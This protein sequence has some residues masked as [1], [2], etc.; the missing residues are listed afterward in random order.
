MKYLSVLLAV[1]CLLTAVHAQWLE[2]TI[3]LDSG[4]SPSALCYNPQNNKV[5]CAN[6]G[7]GTVSVI[8]GATN[9]IAATIAIGEEA[10]DLSCNPL[11]NKVYCAYGRD[12]GRLAVIDGATDSVI[13]TIAVG[14]YPGPLCLGLQDNKVY[15][16]GGEANQ[17]TV[18]D[19]ARDSAIATITVGTMPQ[20]LGYDPQGNTVYCANRVSDDVTVIDGAA[21]SVVGTVAAGYMPCAFCC[22]TRNNRVYCANGGDYPIGNYD[23]TVIVIDGATHRAIDTVMV[24]DFP[25]AIAYNAHN[26]RVYTANAAAGTVTVIDGAR[27]SVIATVPA[28]TADDYERSLCF[29]TLHNKL[30]CVNYQAGNVTVI[31]GATNSVLT[32]IA[33]ESLPHPIAWNPAQS[34]VY[35]ANQRSN[36]IQVIRD[37]TTPAVEESRKPQAVSSKPL[38]TIVRGVLYLP[39]AENGDSPPERLRPTRRGTVPIFRPILLDIS[40]RWVIDLCPGANDVS[41]LAPGVYFVLDKPQAVRKVVIER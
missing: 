37:T 16:I 6:Y 19:G 7:R 30:Y 27:D 23:S 40:G 29:D 25:L 39:R 34:R 22:N 41:R 3:R 2:T 18:I 31:D 26:N 36:S 11:G 21:D 35:V 20:A 4:A 9:V 1:G 5:Y 17:V 10:S 33:L 13:A 32:T 24:G 38:P 28:G 15:C 14:P 8:N 12:S